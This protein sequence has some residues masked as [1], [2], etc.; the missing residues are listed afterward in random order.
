MKTVFLSLLLGIQMM[1]NAQVTPPPAPPSPPTPPEPPSM[2]KK[3]NGDTVKIKL[4][5]RDIFIIERK[6]EDKKSKKENDDDDDDD[7]KS[8]DRKHSNKENINPEKKHKKSKGADVDFLDID[9]GLNLLQSNKVNNEVLVNDLENKPFSSWSWTL[10]FLPTKIYLGSK[11]VQLMTSLGWRI[12][13]LTFK[14]KLSFEP[15][16]TLVYTKDDKVKV[17][18]MDFQ[19]LQIPLMLYFQSNKIKGLGRIGMGVGG[20]AGVLVHQESEVR[21]EDVRRKIET[22]EDFGFNTYRY[23]LSSRI[24]I[25]TLKFYANYDLSPTWEKNDFR[26]LECGIWL[27]F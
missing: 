8:I 15:N 10:N 22:E 7:D 11:N 2:E 1:L 12:G 21:R 5:D 20:Y 23:G 27:D 6:S 3:E 16:Q 25:G 9:L 18:S 13:E 17:S 26:T 4:G 19:H 14:E 24:D